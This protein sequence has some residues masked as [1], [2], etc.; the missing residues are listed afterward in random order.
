MRRT[1]IVT[2]LVSCGGS[3]VQIAK[4]QFPF[5][6]NF[7][8][9]ERQKMKRRLTPLVLTLT[10]ASWLLVY[11]PTACTP[12]KVVRAESAPGEPG[13]DLPG[14]FQSLIPQPR[15]AS[16][17]QRAP[18]QQDSLSIADVAAKVSP[19]VVSV[20]SKRARKRRR[21]RSPFGLPFPGGEGPNRM[22]KGLGSGIILSADGL[23]LT[24]HH[25]IENADEITVDT[26]NTQYDATIVGKD[27][28]TDVAILQLKGKVSG[29]TPIEYGDSSLLRIGEVVLAVGNPFGIGKTVTMGIVS[30]KGRTEVGIVDYANFIQTDAAINP[31]NSGGALVNMKGELI[32]INTAIFS[33]S[34]GYQGIGFAIPSNMARSISKSLLEDGRVSRGYLGVEIQDLNANL[35]TALGLASTNGVLISNV[36]AG[37]AGAKGGLRQ[38]DVIWSVNGAPT[39]SVN[40]LRNTIAS[41]GAK[42]KVTLKL[43]RDGKP[44]T[45]TLVLGELESGE[46]SRSNP[47]SAGSKEDGGLAVKTLNAQLRQR[48]PRLPKSVQAGV[49]VVGVEPGSKAEDS[50]LRPGDVIVRA[51]RRSVTSASEFRAAQQRKGKSGLMSVLV[52]RQGRSL[53]LALE[54]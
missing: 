48:L 52:F 43:S 11:L 6:K 19:S 42:K 39:R 1:G 7:L 49:V 37:D 14:S 9:P 28:K 27:E 31:G 41:A 21:R 18:G 17:T 26:G 34:G 24:N 51:G 25:V 23:I 33:R 46:K 2:R 35:Q 13:S 30:A 38:G 3:E 16:A 22:D 12:S 47:E 15:F 54:L 4:P 44:K 45:I 29:L 36:R 40:Q 20:L 50:G 10:W 8:L 32:G 53:Y 5:Q